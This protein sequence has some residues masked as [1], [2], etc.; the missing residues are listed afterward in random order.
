MFKR[1]HFI[2]LGLVG[3]LT[4]VFLN[5][6]NQT[7]SQIKLAIGSLF[8]PLF[9]ISRS[10]GQMIS[11]TADATLSR[12][13]LVHEVQQLR[14]QN[15]ELQ[16]RLMLS[17]GLQKENDRL[18][19]LVGWGRQ[20]SGNLRLASVI[21]RDPAN[22][23]HGVQIDIGSREGVRPEMTVVTSEG[24]VGRITSVSFTTSQVTLIG[25]PDCKVSA[26]IEN[27]RETGIITG[28]ASPI[29]SSLVTLS[30][31]PG[32]IALKAGQRVFTSGDGR[33]FPKGIVIGQVAED[34]RQVEL[35]YC[36]ARVKLAT[37]IGSL[38][39]VWVLMR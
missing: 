20:N 6:P 4:L 17:D 34:S 28:R 27:S 2:A 9:G 18:R 29:D 33:I 10:S 31:L 39:E 8:L 13:D 25:N 36:E 12:S 38:E 15:G 5:L 35:G 23:W 30:F 22:W 11:S 16:T 14:R 26:I 32:G 37:G 19:Q 21:S 24:L 1:P 3:M 7:A